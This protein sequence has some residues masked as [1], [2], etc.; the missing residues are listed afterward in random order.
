MTENVVYTSRQKEAIVSLIIEMINAD[1][2]VTLEELHISNVI[3]SELG[4]TD[5]IFRVGCALDVIYAIQI[6]KEM[7]D[8]QKLNTGLLLT[9]IIDADGDVNDN[10]LSLLAHICNETGITQLLDMQDEQEQ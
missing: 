5:D 7:N 9:R 8:E 3:N 10:E 6:V 4:I 2:K 1:R